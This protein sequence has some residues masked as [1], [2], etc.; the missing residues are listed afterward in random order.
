MK[1]GRSWSGIS[2]PL[3]LVLLI[4]SLLLWPPK[5]SPS[6]N[7]PEK[8]YNRGDAYWYLGF[9]L[10][11]G[12]EIFDLYLYKN[13]NVEV[14]PGDVF[15]GYSVAVKAGAVIGPHFLAGLEYSLV[16]DAGSVFHYHGGGLTFFPFRDLGLY[17]KG[18]YIYTKFDYR[19]S[20]NFPGG[21]PAAGKG[22][23]H[24]F[25]VGAGYGLQVGE[26]FTPE[27]EITYTNTFPTTIFTDRG[28]LGSI[29]ITL[30]CSWY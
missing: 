5:A 26:S 11:V 15:W 4:I 1:N 14:G 27:L 9:G 23:G 29:S 13:T 10:G 8:K 24:G 7:D 22:D 30:F 2:T 28:V 6:E 21:W 20:P 16:S 18:S 12:V 17:F 25:R 3:C 19:A